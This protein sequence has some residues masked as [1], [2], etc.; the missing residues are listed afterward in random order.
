MPPHLEVL[1]GGSVMTQASMA[2]NKPGISLPGGKTKSPPKQEV[3]PV[4]VK[5]WQNMT[6]EETQYYT[7]SCHVV[8]HPFGDFTLLVYIHSYLSII[9]SVGVSTQRLLKEALTGKLKFFF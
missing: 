1:C 9:S 4:A 7:I 5:T 3:K 6:R 2:A 8:S